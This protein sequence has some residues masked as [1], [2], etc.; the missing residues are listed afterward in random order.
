MLVRQDL[1]PGLQIA[2][3]VHAAFE[4]AHQHPDATTTWLEDSNYIVI[5]SVPDEATL[6]EHHTAASEAPTTLV[7]EPDIGDEAT[8]LAIGPSGYHRRL[9]NLPLAGRELAMT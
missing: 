6:I 5:L 2:Q 7:R 9:S 4:F 3:A 8:A 1:P